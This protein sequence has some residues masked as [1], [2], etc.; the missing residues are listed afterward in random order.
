MIFRWFKIF[1]AADFSELDLVS[2]KYTLEL[3]GV[4]IKDI[5]VTQGVG[6]GLTYEGV[7]IPVQMNEKNPTV[8]DGFASYINEETDDVYLGIEV[9]ES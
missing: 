5:L 3:E 9:D 1:N 4:G 8:V 6:L 2:K 7:F